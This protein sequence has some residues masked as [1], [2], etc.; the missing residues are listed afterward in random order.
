MEICFCTSISCYNHTLT[1]LSLFRQ[2]HR[3]ACIHYMHADVL[4]LLHAYMPACIVQQCVRIRTKSHAHLHACFHACPR[5]LFY[6]HMLRCVDALHAHTHTEA[7]VC[8]WTRTCIQ[9]HPYTDMAI[10][11]RHRWSKPCDGRFFKHAISQLDLLKHHLGIVW[12]RQAGRTTTPP[13]TH[14][15]MVYQSNPT[16]FFWNAN[17][18]SW[19]IDM[20]AVVKCYD[21]IR[22]CYTPKFGSWNKIVAL[23]RRSIVSRVLSCDLM[24]NPGVTYETANVQCTSKF[25]CFL[26]TM[27]LPTDETLIAL[28][29]N[30][31]MAL[32]KRGSSPRNMKLLGAS[33]PGGLTWQLKV[34]GCHPYI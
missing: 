16:S 10:W 7:G 8:T 27:P 15:A 23:F 11:W 6:D 28:Q 9:L 1:Y 22:A 30:V 19:I 26:N 12:P 31:I 17:L 34:L 14:A 5:E 3:P 24:W 18:W 13:N 32:V 20:C 2:R 29:H 33:A 4:A 21:R 25:R